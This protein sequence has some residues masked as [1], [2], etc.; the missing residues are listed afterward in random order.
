[1]MTLS[2]A[3]SQAHD[4]AKAHCVTEVGL[5]KETL[6][7][8]YRDIRGGVRENVIVSDENGVVDDPLPVGVAFVCRWGFLLDDLPEW[9]GGGFSV[10]EFL[11]RSDGILLRRGVSDS[12]SRNETTWHASSW[13][14]FH[15][16]APGTGQGQARSWLTDLDYE[17]GSP[18][19]VAIDQSTAG[20]YPGMPEEAR[21]QAEIEASARRKVQG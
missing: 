13:S 14:M 8:P 7:V 4:A 21:V 12:Y 2:E 9:I 3:K 11:L 10:G 18:T 6:T 15:R 19:P 16:F 1:M 20:P 17:L 5:T